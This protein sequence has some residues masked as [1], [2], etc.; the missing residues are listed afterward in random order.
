MSENAN[1]NWFVRHKILTGIILVIVLI[2]IAGAIGGGS[3]NSESTKQ[4]TPTSSTES[5]DTPAQTEAKVVEEAVQKPTVPT[6]YQS[7]LVKADSYANS[8]NMSKK[9]V[10]DQLTSQYG[11]KFSKKAA[12]YAIDHVKADW[13][14]NALAKAKDYQDQMSMSPAAIHDQL[15]SSYGEKFT[16]KQADYAIKHLNN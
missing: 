4:A 11:E 13:N 15:T 8:M 6:E 3:N 12:Q 1:D 14:A 10:Y 2:G 16:S 9:G 7:A 5:D